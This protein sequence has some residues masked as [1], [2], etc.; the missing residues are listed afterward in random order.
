MITGISYALKELNRVD[1]ATKTLDKAIDI[2]KEGSYP[3]VVDSIRTKAKWLYDEKRCEE[4]IQSYLEVI[5][6]NEINGENEFVGRD[7]LAITLCYIRMGQW[8]EA[9]EHG[10]RARQYLKIAKCVE[11]VSWCD[12]L[13]ADAYAE[14]GNTDFALD[15]AQR[16]FDVAELKDWLLVKCQAALAQGKAYLLR[17]NLD[18]ASEKLE[19]AREIASGSDDW[20]MIINIEKEF[21]KLHI[22]QG[23]TELAANVER[24]IQSLQEIVE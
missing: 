4:A 12:A 11:E 22:V 5:Q 13:T 18:K 24:R 10:S 20:E 2:L 23:K 9:I 16:A 8:S 7:L 17:N 6:I 14:L 3:F 15:I 19:I 1:E 21:I